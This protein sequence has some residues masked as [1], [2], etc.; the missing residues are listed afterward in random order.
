MID[1]DG[2]DGGGQLV[3]TALTLSALDREAFR[4]ERVRG[5]RSNPGLKRQHLACVKTVAA[6]T[7]ADIEGAAIGSETLRFEPTAGPD[8]TDAPDEVAVDI[9]TAGSVTL[10][11]DTLLPLAT[12]IDGPVRA[13][14]TGGTDVQ[15]SPSTD[16]L[17]RVK[18]PLLRGFGL[19]ADVAVERRG[20]FPAGGGELAVAVQPSSLEPIEFGEREG[21]TP[22]RD[23]PGIDAPSSAPDASVHA[24]AATDLD[25]G[26]TADEL[27]DAAVTELHDRGIDGAA[28]AA[29]ASV[30]A[31]SPGSVL[32]VAVGEPPGPGG[33]TGS[34]ASR[35]GFVGYGGADDHPPSLAES[36]ADAVER[37]L[38]TGAP[39]DAHLA[40]QLVVWVALAGGAVPIP[41]LTDHVRTNVDLVSEFGY[42]VSIADRG[43]T[44]TVVSSGDG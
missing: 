17:R 24:V 39:V 11:A 25:G 15:W 29:T 27:A 18:L 33:E 44:P 23:A 3:R 19:D 7:D 22:D 16:Y 9:R 20:F 2:S 13:D 14:L 28:T 41:R 43:G 42:D 1:L 38:A 6:L 40:D 30:D 5:N 35:A 26:D 8:A 32:T 37:W 10:V 21:A 34:P 12:R 36:V 4:M 31:D